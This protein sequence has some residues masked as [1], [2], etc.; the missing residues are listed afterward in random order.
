MA[1]ERPISELFE[2]KVESEGFKPTVYC[3]EEEDAL[4][5]YF[6]NDPDYRKRINNRITLYISQ[7]TEEIVGCQI[8]GIRSI[9]EDLPYFIAAEHKRFRLSVVFAAF[10]G[11][12]EDDDSRRA[13]RELGR[14]AS[15]ADLELVC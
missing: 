8:K 7:E 5:F 6:K 10:L 4:F 14:A 11:T 9:L 3:G 2:L 15:E 12:V 1:T 13:Y